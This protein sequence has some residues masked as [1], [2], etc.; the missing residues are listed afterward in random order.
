M[1]HTY[2]ESIKTEF[3][4]LRKGGLFYI[5]GSSVISQVG[6]LISSFLVIRGLP[7]AEYG[8]YVNA[9]NL[10]SYAAIFVGLGMASA[11][12]QFCSEHIPEQQKKEIYHYSFIQ[13][14]VFNILLALI[15][16]LLAEVKRQ[17]GNAT[18][19]H[20]LQLM[21]GLPFIAYINTLIQT[22]LRIQ[23]KNQEFA[24]INRSYTIFTVS[25]NIFF[26][27]ILGIPGLILSTYLANGIAAGVGT[28]FL[29]KANFI[30]SV[31]TQ[32]RSLPL[33]KKKTITKY[34]VLCALTNFTSTILVL[35]DIT[36]LDLTLSDPNILAD[37]KV[38][39]VIP[40]A[41]IFIPACLITYFYP[42]MVENY[43]SGEKVFKA[44][45]FRLIK[46]F[47]LINT[48]VFAG[49][50]LF[51]PAIIVL[52][53]GEKYKNIIPIF[54]LLCLNYW[55]TASFR[56][57]LG[58]MI[59]VVKAV[60][61]NLLHT[62]IAGGLNIVLDLMLIPRLGPIGAAV[63]TVSVT[64]FITILEIVYFQRFFRT[65]TSPQK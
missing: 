4:S 5:F 6:G 54:R 36:C 8:G 43:S 10:Y 59:V 38:A 45:L 32:P 27:K 57:L 64:S 63:A 16:L 24:Y 20:Y 14:N 7:K 60:N 47:F 18:V 49:L 41:C 26:T 62:T 48:I 61:V 22:V 37:Y 19:A 15:I 39:S 13:G 3:R 44:Y 11:V 17:T 9:N 55:I 33:H 53:Y 65:N 50:M 42:H 31:F 30:S 46:V 1:L 21:C 23:R 52:L 34:A 58:N 40:S 29:E 28:I 25:G 2:F 51:A 35:L 56:K 12:M